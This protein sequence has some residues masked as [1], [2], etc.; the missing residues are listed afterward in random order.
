MKRIIY[1][2]LFFI[3]I[4]L[5]SNGAFAVVANPKAIEVRQS[6]KTILSIFLKGDEKFSWAKTIDGYTL[7]KAKNGDFVYAISDNKQGILPSDIIA[8]NPENRDEREKNFLRNTSKE[9]FFSKD[10]ISYLKSLWDFKQSEEFKEKLSLAKDANTQLKILVLLADF[11]DKP[12]TYNATDF[13]NLFN[14]V[15]YSENGNEGSVKDYFKAS[16]FNNV[17]LISGVYG[18]YTSSAGYASYGQDIAG[19]NGARNL[20]EEVIVL[21]DNDVDF[22]EYTNGTQYVSC[23]FMIFAGCAA[24]SGEPDAIWPH[25]SAIYPPLLKDGVY[26]YDY[27]CAS[28]LEGTSYYGANPPKIG[29]VCHEFSHVLGLE[30]TYDTD[31]ELNGSATTSDS[32][33]VMSSGSYNNGGRTPCL[34]SA[35]QR[36]QVGFLT[37]VELSGS[38]NKTLPELSENNVAFKITYN[39]NEF[40]VFENRQQKGWDAFLPGHGMLIT[41]IDK[42]VPGFNSN[43]ANC[44][45]QYM[46]INLLE[47]SPFNVY[48]RASNPF[49]GTSNNTSFTDNTNPNSLSNDGTPINKPINNIRE[50]NQT[51]NISFDF[52]TIPQNA[53]KAIT[54]SITRL[55]FDTIYVS[56]TTSQTTDPIVEKGVIYSTNSNPTFQD[57]KVISS[58]SASSFICSITNILPSTTYYVRAYVKNN[59]NV[60]YYG[61]IIKVTS[62]CPSIN[63]F[64]F[65]ESFEE[66]VFQ[67][68]SEEGNRYVSNTW[69]IKDTLFANS[70]FIAEDGY[71]FI[72][73]SNRYL[74]GQDRKLISPILN[75]SLLSTPYL[76]FNYLIPQ[77]GNYLDEL[78]VLY[79]VSSLDNWQELKTITGNT[80]QWET[81]SILLPNKTNTYQ[82]AFQSLLY[83][84][85]GVNIDNVIVSEAN[86]L[87]YCQSSTL[88]VDNIT[89]VS[90]NVSFNVSSSGYTP[91]IEKGV[92]YSTT[93]NPTIEDSYISALNNNLG[94]ASLNIS[95]LEPNTTYYF[96]S[97]AK[98]QGLLSYGNTLIATTKCQRVEEFPHNFYAED[99]DS[100][101]F[102]KGESWFLTSLN[103][104][105]LPFEGENF[106]AFKPNVSS[107]SKLIVPLMNLQEH[108][109]AKLIFYYNKPSSANTL[110]IYYRI[111]LQDS[112]HLLETFTNETSSWVKDSVSLTNPSNDYYIAFEGISNGGEG[113]FLD[114]IEVSA[115]K[116]TPTILSLGAELL[117]YNSVLVRGDLISAGYSPIIQK[118]VC[119]TSNSS[120][121]TI[122]DQK[123]ISSTNNLGE[124][125]L[126]AEN[127]N[128]QTTYTF[129]VFAKNSFGVV[130]GNAFSITTPPTPIFNNSIIGDQRLCFNSV[131][132]TIEGLLPS[133]GN[134]HYKYSWLKS[135]D[136]IVWT[137]APED[138][139][140]NF[141]PF[142]VQQSEY[143][144]RVVSSGVVSDTSNV[145]FIKVYERTRA[146]NVFREQD[147]VSFGD[148]VKMELRASMGDSLVWERRLLEYS[149]EELSYGVNDKHL[150]D[151]PENSG[152]YFYRVR[153]R[154]GV[155]SEEISG[156]D[157]TYVKQ[158]I[159]FSDIDN[160]INNDITI[161]PNPSNG[162]ININFKGKNSFL[163]N[164]SLF[165]IE[166]KKIKDKNNVGILSGDNYFDFSPLI[167]GSY[168]LLIENN[169]LQIRK[170][171]IISNK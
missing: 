112:W 136:S 43:C 88:S 163:C 95:S 70:I 125:S 86:S 60:Y 24:S 19:N 114:N 78:K 117:T 151:V 104:N 10:Q 122:D 144:K 42:T 7:L 147:T 106:F 99:I 133:G 77:R 100:N 162:K 164:I 120:L 132:T 15:G 159:G 39:N 51:K 115:I 58:N 8:H 152:L 171:I 118:G 83:G 49:P 35:Y 91:L 82:I 69:K 134:G 142:R 57:N 38:G 25:R 158:K 148:S 165:N 76:K 87:A 124:F 127:L 149:W 135:Q 130:Y 129:R 21:A 16:T 50:N 17:D 56:V 121:P 93:P 155:C 92:V 32:W 26:I 31:Y 113:I 110:K 84:G 170:V 145:A 137:N 89:D 66:N 141:V 61:E 150:I 33:D 131:S 5:F 36:S 103:G 41:H 166:G 2:T 138:T 30:D 9:L 59:Y 53:P 157:Y 146:G 101:C 81:D 169:K 27:G 52:G 22:S 105:I 1:L 37:L 20:L 54:N 80:N 128:E 64:P 46:G 102:D 90:V 44:N 62:P 65:E 18:P 107:S 79:R 40:L 72:G 94:D 119:Y 154:N 73:I 67:C 28:E 160:D 6:D 29:T 14:Q 55:T 3:S 126:I 123:V 45:P 74:S 156:E 140:Q 75:L 68:W 116:Q 139:L 71:K 109:E 4:T 97:Y 12:F 23:V 98:N 168:I 34:W 108:Q 47:A 48:N 96:R 85:Y 13:D 63:T 143:F 167:D 11:P 111:S 161:S 153:V